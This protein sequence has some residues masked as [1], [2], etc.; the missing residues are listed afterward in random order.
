[1]KI[2]H[3]STFWPFPDGFTHYTEALMEG[4]AA[5]EPE[6]QIIVA[7]RRAERKET[8]RYSCLPCYMPDEDFVEPIATALRGIKPDVAVFQYNDDVF[9]LDNRLPRLLAALREAGIRTVVNQHSV[10]LPDR[11]CDIRPGGTA[12]HFDRAVAAEVTRITVHSDRMRRDLLARGVPDDKITV[13]PHGTNI[14][15]PLDAAGCR[16]RLGLNER[17]PVVLF[18]G[19]IWLG[20]GLDF[21]LDVFARTRARVP[22][23]QLY[24]AG[25]TRKKTIYG[26][27]YMRYLRARMYYLGIQGHTVMSGGYLPEDLVDTTY[28]AADVVAMP[29]RQAYSSVSGVV[30]QA[31]GI[32]RLMLCSDI[33]K[34]DEVAAISPAMVAHPKDLEGWTARLTRL[35]SDA[36]LAR[37][38]REKISAFAR[39]TRWDVVGKRHLA[40]YQELCGA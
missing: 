7:D 16:R 13:L 33:A 12:A 26:E 9:G 23:A 31:A 32:G 4:L 5:H 34:F 15:E 37:Q 17:G 11:R 19:Y 2:C 21:L 30:H 10:F 27:V 39:E 6:Q 22:D 25:Y 40:L 8:A 35:L 28:S 3:V 14:I 29:Y 18:F 20:K 36:D 38:L 24:I 1:M